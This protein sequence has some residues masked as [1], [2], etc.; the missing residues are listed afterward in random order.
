MKIIDK[1]IDKYIVRRTIDLI[2]SCCTIY[3]KIDIKLIYEKRKELIS[4]KYIIL[5]KRNK[6]AETEY[7]V[8][9]DDLLI[10]ALDNYFRIHFNSAKVLDSILELTKN[11]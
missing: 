1:I 6:Q 11:E 4:D 10:N 2:K 7:K 9:C 3:Y 5:V 8:I